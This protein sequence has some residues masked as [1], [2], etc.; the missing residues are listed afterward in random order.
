MLALEDEGWPDL[1]DVSGRAGGAEQYPPFPHCLS[2]PAGL[3]GGWHTGRPVG[4]EIDAEQQALAPDIPDGR[5][6][7]R[8][9]HQPLTQVRADLR[10]VSY[11][12]L[13][14]DD[15]EDGERGRAGHRVAAEGAEQLRLRRNRPEYR[16][17][18]RHSGNRE[19]VAHRLSHHHHVGLYPGGREAPQAGTAPAV[20]G[21]NFVGHEEAAQ[22]PYPPGHFSQV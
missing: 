8:E 14:L 5:V 13:V 20:T 1:Q 6:E 16:R 22:G 17:P 19:P 2:N 10:G 4:D 7:V 21:L 12:A 18:D 11:Q 15:I 3:A 9:L